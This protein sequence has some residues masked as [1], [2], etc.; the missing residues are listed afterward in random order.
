MRVALLHNAA[1]GDGLSPGDLRREIAEAGHELIHE[2]GKG[3]ELRLPLE[4]SVD[5]IAVAGGDGTVRNAVHAVAGTGVALA[6]LP[7]GT[8]NNIAGALG[9]EGALP[10][11]IRAWERARR[12]PFDLGRM[13]GPWGGG[14]F[15]EGVGIG[16]VPEATAAA[17]QRGKENLGDSADE[18]LD[19]ARRIYRE[20]LARLAPKALSLW[21]DGEKLDGEYLLVEVLNIPSVGPNLAFSPE[22]DPS[23]GLLDLVTAGETER[24]ELMALLERDGRTGPVTLPMRRVRNLEIGDGDALH[25]DDQVRKGSEVGPVSIA[26]EPASVEFLV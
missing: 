6:I 12:V 23:D 19:G 15:L 22:A 18:A 20:T 26:I 1:A 2:I 21:A 3:E 17:Q 9:I 4:P 16:L 8:A 25:V 7:L 13:R 5:L 11:L 14:R 10:D 24:D